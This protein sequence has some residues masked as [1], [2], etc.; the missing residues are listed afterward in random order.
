MLALALTLS[1]M[2]V[3]IGKWLNNLWCTFI[4][5]G[6]RL[7]SCG[8]FGDCWAQ[9][10]S[11]NLAA[12]VHLCKVQWL[13]PQ[14]SLKLACITGELN[15]DCQNCQWLMPSWSANL[16]W[17]MPSCRIRFWI[18]WLGTVTGVRHSAHFTKQISHPFLFF[19]SVLLLW[20]KKMA[21]PG[22]AHHHLVNR[23]HHRIAKMSWPFGLSL[24][25]T[26]RFPVVRAA[27]KQNCLAL[28]SVVS[29]LLTFYPFKPK[30]FMSATW[31]R[32]RSCHK[33]GISVSFVSSVQS[34]L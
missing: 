12:I 15:W 21:S 7:V 1:P 16:S 20:K 19:L 27:M 11:L 6:L 9:W 34:W 8:H 5:R 22:R 17:C 26:P 30:L 14:H 10:F 31:V 32:S 3:S 2:H 33:W 13:S 29:E 24:H 25:L 23:N 4:S 18:Q 28:K